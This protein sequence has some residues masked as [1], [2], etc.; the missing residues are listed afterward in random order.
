MTPRT[1]TA[2]EEARRL[3]R[4][5]D[6]LGHPDFVV[7]YLRAELA[8]DPD[9]FLTGWQ[10]LGRRMDRFHDAF[11]NALAVISQAARRPP[12]QSDFALAAEPD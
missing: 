12:R 10:L 2:H 6:R 9:A 3:I 4:R 1:L 5:R 8:R 11:V 7:A